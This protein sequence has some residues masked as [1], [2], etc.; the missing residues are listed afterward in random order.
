MEEREKAYTFF[1]QL[2]WRTIESHAN[3]ILTEPINSKGQ[4]GKECAS[5]LFN[6]LERNNIHVRYFHNHRL[7]ESKIRISIGTEM[8]M[9]VLY[10]KI[11]KW[12]NEES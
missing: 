9:N 2:G 10:Q 5:S 11:N 7:T 4:V 3:F 1:T 12:R 6:Y 8:Q